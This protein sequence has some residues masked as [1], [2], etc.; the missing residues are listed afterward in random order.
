MCNRFALVQ[1]KLLSSLDIGHPLTHTGRHRRTPRRLVRSPA[2]GAVALCKVSSW[3]YLT[4]RSTL[5]RSSKAKGEQELKMKKRNAFT[6]VELLVVIGIIAV[7]IAILLPSLNRARRSAMAV[8]CAS[9]LRQ[10]GVAMQMYAG[11]HQ[12]ILPFGWIGFTGAGSAN[13]SYAGLS[14]TALQFRRVSW[15]DLISPNLGIKLT[16][17]ESLEIALRSVDEVRAR[18]RR[19]F[20]CPAD[21]FDLATWPGAG[22]PNPSLLARR[23]YSGNANRHAPPPP[24]PRAERFR[25]VFDGFYNNNI[26]IGV[27][28]QYPQAVKLASVRPG[29][30]LLVERPDPWNVM[31]SESLATTN[32]PA[33][34]FS[35]GGVAG[36]RKKAIHNDKW[37]YLLSDGSVSLLNWRDTSGPVN[38]PDGTGYV[39]PGK[40]WYR[41]KD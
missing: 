1:G 17:V 32:S 40:M 14:G 9:N 21:D 24:G 10:I 18:A 27:K 37:N 11:A 16:D 19:V 4:S 8:Q 2:P 28:G 20:Q 36:A 3:L 25:G 41:F 34:Q 12:G 22:N 26:P 35:I 7:L 30:I 33:E 31:G 5:E 13:Y 38:L 39:I 23:T 15:D 6:L 29:T